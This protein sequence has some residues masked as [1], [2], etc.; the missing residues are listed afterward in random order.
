MTTAAEREA[1]KQEIIRERRYW[2]P[3]H[4]GLL[5]HSPGFLRAYVDFISA[6]W[7]SGHLEPK[8]REFIYIAVDGAVS[9]LYEKGMRRHIEFALEAGATQAEVLQV[10]QLACATMHDTHE[11]GMRVLVDELRRRSPSIDADL[12]DLGEAERA[13]KRRFVEEVGYWPECGDA[14]LRFAPRFVEG[15]LAFRSVAWREGPLP[16]KVKE[17]IGLAIHAAP[18]SLYEPGVRAH[19]QRALIHGATPEEISEVLQLAGAI[20]IHTATA[21]IPA[22][23]ETASKRAGG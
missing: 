5:E 12:A 4:E 2:H 9:H 22:V 14:L 21:G 3:F 23:M 11:L 13:I 10:V 20:A 1:L 15:F 17:F 7:K 19:M 18:T 8:V 6:P 16:A